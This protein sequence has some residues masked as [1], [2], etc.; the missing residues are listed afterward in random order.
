M[1][2]DPIPADVVESAR[3]QFTL[4]AE[5]LDGNRVAA[6]VVEAA[7][8]WGV[9]PLW[10]GVCA[11][12]L[13][14]L[15]GRS[16]AEVAV[17]HAFSEGLRSGLDVLL[18]GPGTPPPAGGILLAGAEQE[19]HCLGLHALA[20]ALREAGLGSL[21]LGAALP[22][23]ALASAVRRTRPHTVVVWS[24][25][26]M[27]GRAYRAVRFAREFP[28]VRVHGAG[29]GWITPPT[30]PAGHL[31]NLSDAL[32]ACRDAARQRDEAR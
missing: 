8:R 20:A 6:L 10:E 19:L 28:S 12:M 5:D 14:A 32:A 23:P 18:R 17:E 13:A 25:T 9:A 3:K 22:W 30:T 21:L 1:V 26:P 15:P 2:T 27:T 24:Q 7:G 11:P 31:T 16:A 29:P 4:A